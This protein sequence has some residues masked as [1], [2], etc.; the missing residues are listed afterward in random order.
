[1]NIITPYYATAF[2]GKKWRK[3]F[4]FLTLLNLNILKNLFELKRI[5]A[6]VTPFGIVFKICLLKYFFIV[7]L[8]F[9][10]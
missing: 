7:I 6:I 2:D 8:H 9:T 10:H 3:K 4:K 1:M 5:F